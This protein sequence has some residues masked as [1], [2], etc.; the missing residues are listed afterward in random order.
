MVEILYIKTRHAGLSARSNAKYSV[1]EAGT[2]A[3]R[4]AMMKGANIRATYA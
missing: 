4:S 1:M 3:A 2:P